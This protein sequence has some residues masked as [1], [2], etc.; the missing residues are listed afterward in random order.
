MGGR[1]ASRFASSSRQWRSLDPLTWRCRPP[2]RAGFLLRFTRSIVT[3]DATT[4]QGSFRNKPQ[5]SDYPSDAVV[6]CAPVPVSAPR[7]P[8]GVS[9]LQASGNPN[10]VRQRFSWLIHASV[11]DGRVMSHAIGFLSGRCKTSH[12]RAKESNTRSMSGLLS[13]PGS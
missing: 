5:A 6:V 7:F 10:L 9:E 11:R 1:S 12:S 4:I 8:G 13:A 2:S 3:S